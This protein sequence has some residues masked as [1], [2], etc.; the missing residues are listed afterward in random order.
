MIIN[1]EIIKMFAQFELD[2]VGKSFYEKGYV[3]R[4]YAK[5]VPGESKNNIIVTTGAEVRNEKGPLKYFRPSATIFHTNGNIQYVCNCEDYNY[6]NYNNRMCSHLTALMYKYIN[7]YQ[8]SIVEEEAYVA[9]DLLIDKLKGVNSSISSV[10][11]E[12]KLE[13]TLLI[14]T[15]CYVMPTV[16][17]KVGL[18][19][20]Y[21][22]INMKNFL[23]AVETGSFMEFGKNYSYDPDL[24][25][26]NNIVKIL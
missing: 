1:E 18:D 14:N 17:L 8:P 22:V 16:E 11:R 9:A 2:E 6:F 5:K 7:E 10:K 20:T 19:K 23:K 4:F 3:N 21:V 25:E 12:L 24:Q 15:R 13:I 26:F